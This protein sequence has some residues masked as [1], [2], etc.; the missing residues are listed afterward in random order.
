MQIS[1][2]HLKEFLSLEMLDV[3][4]HSSCGQSQKVEALQQQWIHFSRKRSHNF[5]H[6]LFRHLVR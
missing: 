2:Q 5:M 6:R 3:V 1:R 4:N